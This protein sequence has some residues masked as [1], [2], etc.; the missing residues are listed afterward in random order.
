MPFRPEKYHFIA[1]APGVLAD[2]GL[3][4]AREIC[5]VWFGFRFSLENRPAAFPVEVTGKSQFKL[6]VNGKSVL[7]GPCRSMREIA[8]VDTLDISA[9]LKEGENRLVFQVFSYPEKPV[10]EDPR[11][12]GPN[13]CYGDSDGPGV[14]LA[15]DFGVLTGVLSIHLCLGCINSQIWFVFY[16]GVVV[17]FVR[18]E[19]VGVVVVILK[20]VELG[21]C[22]E[23][24]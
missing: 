13:Y 7:F 20:C 1:P 21:L 16:V 22:S 11:S 8:Y 5:P 17:D 4:P 23:P 18:N 10:P 6:F 3:D 14:C 15:G 9:E 24:L 19:V 12:Q 2:A